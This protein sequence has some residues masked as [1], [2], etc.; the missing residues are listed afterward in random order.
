MDLVYVTFLNGRP[1]KFSCH[2]SLYPFSYFVT[3][4][5]KAKRVCECYLHPSVSSFPAVVTGVVHGWWLLWV[6]TKDLWQLSGTIHW[7]NLV[8]VY[9]YLRA[10][11]FLCAWEITFHICRVFTDCRV[12]SVHFFKFS[13]FLVCSA[14]GITFDARTCVT[15]WSRSRTY[16]SSTNSPASQCVGRKLSRVASPPRSLHWGPP[17][18]GGLT[19][20]LPDQIVTSISLSF[21]SR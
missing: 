13:V 15:N 2:P 7:G 14:W 6:D 17:S 19:L 8:I 12:F 4:V 11:Y 9:I 20:M 10:A 3:R 21:R 1:S 16:T 5:C 18:K